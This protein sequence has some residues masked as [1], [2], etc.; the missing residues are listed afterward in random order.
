MDV[1][2]GLDLRRHLTL[3]P[4]GEEFQDQR[5]ASP[6]LR[7]SYTLKNGWEAEAFASLF[8]P[9]ILPPQNSAYSLIAHPTSLDE[10]DEFD[11]AIGAINFGGRLTMR[12]TER[13]TAMVMYTNRRRCLSL[14]GSAGQQRKY[15]ERL[16]CRPPE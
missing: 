8:T 9:T 1:I 15:G 7:V 10:R 11:D 2:N 5:I 12:L 13:L 14:C 6:T 4:G 3:G 16:L